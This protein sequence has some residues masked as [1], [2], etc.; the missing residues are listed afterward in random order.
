MACQ[1]GKQ[2]AFPFNKSDS[3]A[4]TRFDIVHS[5][6]WVPFLVPTMGS[7]W[8]FVVFVDDFSRYTWIYLMKN[9]YEII[10]IYCN[11]SKMIKT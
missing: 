2:L 8:Y 10:T 7:S 5:D 6:V 3:Y 4:L 11:F 1:V 9:C